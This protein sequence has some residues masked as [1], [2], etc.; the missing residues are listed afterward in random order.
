MRTFRV[1]VSG[2]E[3]EVSIE[4]ITEKATAPARS[5]T[6]PVAPKKLLNHQHLPKRQP[7]NLHPR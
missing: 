3:Y 4:E 7:Q 5:E 1:I 6:A 2:N